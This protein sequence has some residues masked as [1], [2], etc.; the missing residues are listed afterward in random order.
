MSYPCS[1][2][3]L[4]NEFSEVAIVTTS[5]GWSSF[6]KGKREGKGK[7]REDL[8]TAAYRETFEETGITKEEITLIP[9]TTLWELSAKGNPSVF[10]F[11][12]KAAKKP[13]VPQD[14]E[15]L[16]S[17]SWVSLADLS[18]LRFKASRQ[19]L[20]LKVNKLKIS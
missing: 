20:I 7:T 16:D 14:P 19:E 6:P 11:V 12:G 1:G 5:R 13:L 9:E 3:V 4:F 8:L 15:E 18:K 17:A 2:F 10:Y